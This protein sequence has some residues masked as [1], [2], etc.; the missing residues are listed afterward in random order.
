MSEVHHTTETAQDLLS[1]NS[2]CVISSLGQ[3]TRTAVTTL[4]CAPFFFSE[5]D[6]IFLTKEITSVVLDRSGITMT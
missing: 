3:L 1:M 2:H 4:D 6:P 5:N